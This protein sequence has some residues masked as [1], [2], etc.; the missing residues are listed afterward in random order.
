MPTLQRRRL[1]KMGQLEDEEA[2]RPA[3]APP[4][5][6]VDRVPETPVPS[7]SAIDLTTA[8]PTPV[9]IDISADGELPRL[10]PAKDP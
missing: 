8:P 1:V 4:A 6:E 5:A 10:H 7:S 3:R 9:P 2:A